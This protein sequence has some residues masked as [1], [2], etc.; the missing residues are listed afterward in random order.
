MD[1]GGVFDGYDWLDNTD[2]VGLMMACCV[3]D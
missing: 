3:H 1:R 2:G